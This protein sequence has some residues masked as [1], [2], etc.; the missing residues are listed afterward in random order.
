MN[1]DDIERIFINY[2]NDIKN[3]IYIN[4]CINNDLVK[5]NIINLLKSEEKVDKNYISKVK[6]QILLEHF[7]FDSKLELYFNILNLID[8]LLENGKVVD[9]YN[10]KV[11]K[12]VIEKCLEIIYKEKKFGIDKNDIEV[13]YKIKNIAYAA[14][15]LISNGYKLKITEGMVDFSERE[16]KRIEN[17]IENYVIN[18]GGRN[19]C[20]DIFSC[21]N[22]LYNNEQK[23]FNF[24]HNIPKHGSIKDEIVLK[25][26]YGYLFNLCLKNYT[27]I[28]HKNKKKY[29]DD[30]LKL[31]KLAKY[32][33]GVHGFQKFN[34]FEDML[35]DTTWL[36]NYVLNNILY[37]KMYTF[38]NQ[39]NPE[40][41]PK[42]IKGMF[43]EL[44]KEYNLEEK[45][46]YDLEEMLEVAKVLLNKSGDNM[47]FDI[48]YIKKH[49]ERMNIKKIKLILDDLCQQRKKVNNRFNSLFGELNFYKRPLIKI[50][51]NKYVLINSSICA[52]AFVGAL[53]DKFK[54]YVNNFDGILGRRLE[55]FIKQLLLE[56][57]I[58]FKSGYYNNDDECDIV[59][60]TEKKVIFIEVKKKSINHKAI[61]GDDITYFNDIGKSLFLSQKQ[62]L[63]HE[64]NLLKE[65]K[66]E[67]RKFNSKKASKYLPK[68]VI[69]LNDRIIEKVSLCF[70]DFGFMNDSE[71]VTNVLSIIPL[72]EVNTS[73]KDRQIELNDLKEISE[74][75]LNMSTKLIKISDNKN[76]LREVFFDTLLISLQQFMLILFDS[77][78]INQ[79]EDNLFLTKYVHTG[80]GN[81]YVDYNYWKRLKINSK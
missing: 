17:N 40:Y 69:I 74:E 75:L 9:I 46:G 59:L 64:L 31:F 51:Q 15:F 57:R 7:I 43:G 67:L 1:T 50:K 8:K 3:N 41:I 60:E 23:R 70:Q 22:K 61:N 12:C 54:N 29:Y 18:L 6:K 25:I 45:I 42:L 71:L 5:K 79:L 32:Y 38:I 16:R 76:N 77:E 37:E 36:P 68:E 10:E 44:F 63:K 4:K 21:I 28:N 13:E 27:Y 66:L 65:G 33:V 48:S 72:I 39:W 34:I 53:Q 55:M 58:H 11:W 24:Q 81:F 52:F 80:S 35:F 47:E 19:L 73:N 78:D 20:S 26:P 30:E 62:L 56:K 49:L 2:V 14:R